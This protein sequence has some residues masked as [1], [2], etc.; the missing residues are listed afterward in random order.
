[1]AENTG[2]FFM[3]TALIL[4]KELTQMVLS[5]YDLQKLASVVGL[6]NRVFI[7]IKYLHFF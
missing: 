2:A 1:V 7:I 3:K 6:I 5:P 4:S